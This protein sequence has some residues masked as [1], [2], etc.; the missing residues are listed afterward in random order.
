VR[1]ISATH[2]DLS[3][4]VAFGRFRQ[5]FYYRLNVIQIQMPALREL[6]EDIAAIAQ[7]V[8]DRL[9]GAQR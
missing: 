1:I 4:R 2:N 8:L 5:I 9:R 6:R 3:E 7:Q